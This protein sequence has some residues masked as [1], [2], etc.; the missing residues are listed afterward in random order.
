MRQEN[1]SGSTSTGVVTSARSYKTTSHPITAC[2]LL[3]AGLHKSQNHQRH[4]L[5]CSS[6]CTAP[7][8]EM[9]DSPPTPLTPPQS[10]PG[11]L[12]ACAGPIAPPGLRCP[13]AHTGWGERGAHLASVPAPETQQ[14]AGGPCCWAL[15]RPRRGGRAHWAWGLAACPTAP[16]ARHL[17]PATRQQGGEEISEGAKRSG[18]GNHTSAASEAVCMRC[19]PEL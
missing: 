10:P 12:H 19:C 9:V 1:C 8:L 5:A 15:P 16:A 11:V 4:L 18:R 13:R 17:S 3:S 6:T 2:L 14:A 7:P